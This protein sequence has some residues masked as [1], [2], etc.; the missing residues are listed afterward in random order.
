MGGRRGMRRRK[1]RWAAEGRG[2]CA[3]GL[4]VQG[5]RDAGDGAGFP[6]RG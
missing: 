4:K 2:G 5:S 3:G 6:G 1:L